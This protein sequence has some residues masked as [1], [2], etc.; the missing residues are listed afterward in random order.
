ML[1][2]VVEGFDVGDIY[3]AR[4]VSIKFVEC[5]A[6]DFNTGRVHLSSYSPKEFIIANGLITVSIEHIEHILYVRFAHVKP[7]L[8]HALREFSH[9]QLPAAV[10]IHVPEESAE[11]EYPVGSP[12]GDLL[13]EYLK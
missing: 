9:F 6:Y 5:L 8:I 1:F 10:V 12:T 2:S 3:D 11:G 13:A 7:E 4:L